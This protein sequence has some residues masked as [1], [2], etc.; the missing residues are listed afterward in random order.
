VQLHLLST[1]GEPSLRDIVDASRPLLQGGQEPTVAY[2]PAASVGEKFV[3]L[4]KV[5]FK[6]LAKV[7]HIDMERNNRNKVEAVLDRA[8]LIYIPGGNTY[9]LSHR[10]HKAN[11]IKS[12]RERVLNGLPLVAFSAGA[13]LCGPTILTTNDMNCCA[14]TSFSGLAL[15]PFNFNVHYPQD[16]EHR[17][18]RDERLWE[19]HHFYDNPVLALED[20]AYIRVTDGVV[21][22]V[23][24]DCWL[25]ERD[26]ERV[27]AEVG[28]I[29]V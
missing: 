10:L 29:N 2:L 22:L 26:K 24:G 3:G 8:A 9:L 4:T 5:A 6:E 28:I 12:I 15:T 18:L 7:D 25:F 19:Y 17:E 1:P 20:G 11:L 14:A 27:K 13:V 23:K 16:D 21:E